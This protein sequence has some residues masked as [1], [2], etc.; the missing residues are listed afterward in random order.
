MSKGMRIESSQIRDM[1][2][3]MQEQIAMGFI[4]D[5]EKRDRIDNAIS[6]LVAALMEKYPETATATI[7]ITKGQVRIS[8]ALTE[9]RV[10]KLA[11]L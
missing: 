11:E 9:S 1:P 3:D 6:E 8:V 10:V 4:K 2:L 7:T 5:P